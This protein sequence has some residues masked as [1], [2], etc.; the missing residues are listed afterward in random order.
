MDPIIE[1]NFDTGYH[2]YHDHAPPGYR[3]EYPAIVLNTFGDGR[4]VYFP[5]PFLKGFARKAD[6]SLKAL[7]R[8]LLNEVLGVSAKI[9]I[10]APVSVKHS[11]MQDGDDWLLHLIHVQK[12]TDAM[13]LDAF[14]RCD[15]IR[16]RVRPGWEVAAVQDA[17]SGAALECREVDGWTEFVVDGIEGHRI[18]RIRGTA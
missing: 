8:T 18:V 1:S 5:V 17:L 4:V 12:Q 9:R 7:F 14:R 15:P 10:E 3:S 13:Y 11:L 2:V 6:P 16:V